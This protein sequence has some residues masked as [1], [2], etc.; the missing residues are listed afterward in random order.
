MSRTRGRERGWPADPEPLPSPVWD[1]H[2]HLESVL[3]FDVPDDAPRHCVT[4]Q[5]HGLDRALDQKL[6]EMS[7]DALEHSEPVRIDLPV[8]NVNRT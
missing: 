4:T 1:N 8:S 6:I 3:A 2:T 5:D 7:S